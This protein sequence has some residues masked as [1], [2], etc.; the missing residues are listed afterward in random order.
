MTS[1]QSVPLCVQEAKET[2]GCVRRKTQEDY[3]YEA[4]CYTTAKAVQTQMLDC[5]VVDA[6]RCCVCGFGFF[7]A[8]PHSRT[9]ATLR[10]STTST[11]IVLAQL[12]DVYGSCGFTA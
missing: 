8:S 7:D 2:A 3:G 5:K 6:N 11:G 9:N 1:F 4:V 10:S 12:E